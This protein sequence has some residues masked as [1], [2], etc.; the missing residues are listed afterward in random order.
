MPY[1][2]DSAFR[3]ASLDAPQLAPVP[4]VFP[5]YFMVR[6]APMDMPGAGGFSLLAR[7]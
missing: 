6:G 7:C 1:P 2:A 5:D 4:T 3:A